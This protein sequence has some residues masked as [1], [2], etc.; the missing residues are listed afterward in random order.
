MQHELAAA[1]TAVGR[2]DRCLHP[3]L[4]GAAS[5]A[6]ADAFDIEGVEGIELEAALTLLLRADLAGPRQRLVE[7]LLK[8][9]A[10]D[11]ACDVANDAAQPKAQ[12]AQLSPIS[13]EL[14]GVGVAP[15]HERGPLGDAQVGLPQRH[16]V[17]AGQ[18]VQPLDRRMHELGV[19]RE[20]DVLGL[21]GRVDS[22]PREVSPPQGA[23][24]MVYPQALGQQQ[25][26]LIAQP[27]APMAEPRALM[28]E[29]VLE[30]LLAG[31]V[32][33]VWAVGPARTYLLVRQGEDML[34]HQQ[35]DHEP[36]LN[37][38]TA[39]GAV[40]RGDL[41]VDPGPVDLAGELHQLVLHVDDLL[42][43]GPEQII[44]LR[45]LA[46]LGSHPEPSDAR[47]ESRARLAE[48]RQKRNRK[49]RPP[50]GPEPCD[51]KTALNGDFDSCSNGYAIF[52]G[53]YVVRCGGCHG[54]GGPGW[55]G[56]P[57]LKTFT[58]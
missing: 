50:H 36:R 58:S 8:A 57:V 53:D 56:L 7:H 17:L 54:H 4:V 10:D 35:A 15:C 5:L 2:S 18:A 52:T 31:E 43:P 40:E 6:L 3:E 16:A 22:D 27:L 26:E 28:R 30:E 37:R 12:Q 47:S 11:L 34:E 33:E 23:T 41:A 49:I 32:L 9:R 42:E 25:L 46:L 14:L 45:R 55:L 29:G 21:N 19:G 39:V 44:R 13:I 24:V 48:N 51:F 20:R 1:G 38:R